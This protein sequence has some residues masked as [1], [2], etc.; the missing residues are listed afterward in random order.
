MVYPSLEA[1]NRLEREGISL[2]VVN[3]RF[4]KPLDEK[5]ILDLARSADAVITV[6]E[7]VN[8]GGFGSMVRALL[9]RHEKFDVR[10]KNIAI[11]VEIYPLGKV[12]QIKKI[13]KLDVDGLVGRVKSFYGS[14]KNKKK[15]TFPQRPPTSK[16]KASKTEREVQR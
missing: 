11:P 6:E 1:A 10:F 5:L 8:A 12:D 7:A 3:A 9:D 4:A 14:K 2:S 16:N 13:Y 15:P